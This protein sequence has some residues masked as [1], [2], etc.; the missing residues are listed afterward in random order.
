MIVPLRGILKEALQRG[1]Q[2]RSRVPLSF[3]SKEEASIVDEALFALSGGGIVQ[4]DVP[5]PLFVQALLTGAG[6]EKGRIIVPAR[7][8]RS[9]RD[10][11]GKEQK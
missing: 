9:D 1:C 8:S 3:R 7:F 4:Q 6:Q 5:I 10:E 2:F 11:G